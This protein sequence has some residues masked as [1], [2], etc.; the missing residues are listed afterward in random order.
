MRVDLSGVKDPEECSVLLYTRNLCASLA[1][2]IRGSGGDGG[3]RRSRNEPGASGGARASSPH[4]LTHTR[5]VRRLVS[6]IF[7][8]KQV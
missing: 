3:G 4:G 5:F 7:F 6:N 2:L 1:R 8:K